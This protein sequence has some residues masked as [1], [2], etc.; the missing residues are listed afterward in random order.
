MWLI[1]KNIQLIMNKKNRRSI[2]LREIK[3]LLRMIKLKMINKIKIN[4]SNNQT[5][6]MM[7]K[8]KLTKNIWN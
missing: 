1:N 8:H 5:I 3:Q 4:K 7:N 2:K 6:Q